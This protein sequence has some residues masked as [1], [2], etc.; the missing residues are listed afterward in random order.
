[1]VSPPCYID[2]VSPYPNYLDINPI[3][4]LLLNH[5]CLALQARL[6]ACMYPSHTWSCTQAPPHSE[7]WEE[8]GY[9]AM[10]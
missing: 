2:Q 5:V 3:H 6:S 10:T 4:V 9:K 1:M 7:I 8:S